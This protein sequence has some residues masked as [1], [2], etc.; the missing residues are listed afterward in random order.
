MPLTV[1]EIFGVLLQNILTMLAS[2]VGI[3]GGAFIVPIM[4]T[5]FKFDIK[6]AAIMSNGLILCRSFVAYIFSLNSQHP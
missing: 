1:S 6:N 5:L 4:I 2:I 3:G